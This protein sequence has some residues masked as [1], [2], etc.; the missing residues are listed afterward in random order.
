MDG[1]ELF[2]LVSN[3]ERVPW[4]RL[5]EWLRRRGTTEVGPDQWVLRVQRPGDR[6]FIEFGHKH[7]Q[8]HPTGMAIGTRFEPVWQETKALTRLMDELLDEF[9]LRFRVRGTSAIVSRNERL[10]DLPNP[11]VIETD[12]IC[13]VCWKIPAKKFSTAEVKFGICSERCRDTMDAGIRIA[14]EFRSKVPSSARAHLA[15]EAVLEK[16]A[17]DDI[18]YAAVAA[19]YSIGK[20]CRDAKIQPSVPESLVQR[21]IAAV[22]TYPYAYFVAVAVKAIALTGGPSVMGFLVTELRARLWE[23]TVN[24]ISEA[25]VLAAGDRPVD[26]LKELILSEGDPDCM[27]HLI[28]CFSALASREELEFLKQIKS[29]HRVVQ[30]A[31]EEAASTIKAKMRE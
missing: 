4:A 13:S 24:Q 20:A 6:I 2:T 12:R 3:P 21:L 10:Y 19:I 28:A 9:D 11:L 25:L 27:A 29:S 5:R 22:D 18:N 15:I 14:Q 17:P 31:L 16:T 26:T 23:P 8:K 7:A 1:I 30:V